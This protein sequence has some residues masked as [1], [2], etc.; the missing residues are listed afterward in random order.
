MATYSSILT[1]KSPT[2][3]GAWQAT[4]LGVA[5]VGHNLVTK[6]S[7]SIATIKICGDLGMT[8]GNHWV[9]KLKKIST[10]EIPVIYIFN[11]KNTK[12]SW[13]QKKIK[14]QIIKSGISF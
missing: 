10:C 4:V 13:T 12:R 6:S 8:F 14:V 1:W 9:K 3:R 2:D 5:R 11:K 7:V